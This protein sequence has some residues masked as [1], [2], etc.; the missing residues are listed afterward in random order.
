M[1][2]AIPEIN[3][4]KVKLSNIIPMDEQMDPILEYTSYYHKDGPFCSVYKALLHGSYFTIGSMNSAK[5]V[6]LNIALVTE[7]ACTAN[8]S[9]RQ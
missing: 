2:S 8:G 4:L 5:A 3:I 6:Y 1:G 7:L 9:I